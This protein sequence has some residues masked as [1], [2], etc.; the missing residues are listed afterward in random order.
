MKVH[1]TLVNNESFMNI[2]Y[3]SAL[4]MIGLKA[5]DLK[6]SSSALYGFTGDSIQALGSIQLAFTIGEFPRMRTIMVE[7]V[8]VNSAFAFNVMLEHPLLG[9]QGAIMSIHHLMKKFPTT[10]GI[11]CL[12]GEQRKAHACYN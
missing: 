7:F 6:P 3:Q 8:V 5:H 1:K 2:L 12:Q 11:G 10:E 9:E 4:E